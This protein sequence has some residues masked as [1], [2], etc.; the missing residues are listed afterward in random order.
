MHFNKF[1]SQYSQGRKLSPMDLGRPINLYDTHFN[2]EPLNQG[3]QLSDQHSPLKGSAS[4][5][6]AKINPFMQ[7]ID[8]KVNTHQT[9][10]PYHGYGS[11]DNY[12]DGSSNEFMRPTNSKYVDW[13]TTKS[14]SSYIFTRICAVYILL[15]IKCIL[16]I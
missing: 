11:R 14:I 2:K 16:K 5:S 7:M 12:F 10:I 9:Q 15:G 1:T 13:N 8:S 6:F 3:A 4:A